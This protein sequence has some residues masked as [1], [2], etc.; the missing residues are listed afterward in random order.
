MFAHILAPVNADAMSE[1]A[2]EVAIALAE[3][4]AGRLTLLHVTE[5]LPTY[6]T[7]VAS[8]L[9]EGEL[10]RAA[11]DYGRA[12]LEGVAKHVPEAIPCR[13][14]LRPGR[15][16]VWRDILAVR[17]ELAAD[18]IVMGTHGRKGVARAFV[19]S[20]AEQVARHALVPVVLVR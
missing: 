16:G 12:L 18:A 1:R 20:V 3:K 4:F 2:V 14:L 9:P 11:S 10:E 19:G 6:S 7:Q 5:P 13:L 15:E 17:Q 8:Y